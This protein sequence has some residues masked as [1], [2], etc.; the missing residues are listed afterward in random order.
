MNDVTVLADIVDSTSSV[1]V[2]TVAFAVTVF[3]LKKGVK[4]GALTVKA[5]APDTLPRIILFVPS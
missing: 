4:M 2:V 5:G 3:V 1:V